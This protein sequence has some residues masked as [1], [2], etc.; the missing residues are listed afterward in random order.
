[1]IVIL[2]G[3]VL[4]AGC[5]VDLGRVPGVGLIDTSTDTANNVERTRYCDQ[6]FSLGDLEEHGLAI[7]GLVLRHGLELD[8]DSGVEY[9]AES[10]TL[11]V[12][13]DLWTPVLDDVTVSQLPQVD[14]ARWYWLRNSIPDDL[15]LYTYDTVSRRG[16]LKPALLGEWSAHLPQVT[17]L[18]FA[19]VEDTWRDNSGQHNRGIAH[20]I[21]RVVILDVDV[22]DVNRGVCVW[23]HEVRKQVNPSYLDQTEYDENGDPIRRVT[24]FDEALDDTIK[25]AIE[26]L[27]W[28]GGT[29]SPGWQDEVEDGFG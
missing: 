20:S 7:G 22:Y 6:E 15:C 10:L 29:Q 24:T 21:G 1:M 12:Q 11:D 2:G 28:L 5:S 13:A 3:A 23:S 18:A 8:D 14:V 25:V 16:T 19:R 4:M 26:E 27:K 9:E 17:Y